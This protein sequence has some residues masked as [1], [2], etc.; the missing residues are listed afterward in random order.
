[1]STPRTVTP[2]TAPQPESRPTTPANPD[3]FLKPDND[4]HIPRDFAT[5]LADYSGIDPANAKAHCLAVRAE[6]WKVH[7]YP[8]I[9]MFL[10][11]DTRQGIMACPGNAF[12]EA[13][14]LLK[15]LE[16]QEPLYLDI[17]CGLGQDLRLLRHAGVPGDR[18]FGTDLLPG[19]IKAGYHLFRDADDDSTGNTIL[20]ASFLVPHDIFTSL[21]GGDNGGDVQ[22][23]AHNPLTPYR[24]RF[25]VVNLGHL[26]HIFSRAEQLEMLT[27]QVIGALL[28]PP[29][30]PQ[31]A[32]GGGALIVGTTV[33]VSSPGG[34]EMPSRHGRGVT[35][36]IHSP[37]SFTALME[38]VGRVT[39]TLW[40]VEARLDNV[41]DDLNTLGQEGLQAFRLAFTCKRRAK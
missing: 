12:E 13:V 4:V 7:R 28:R 25:A 26:L 27:R 30:S 37:E 34:L 41:M 29:V 31:G 23:S 20:S 38:D 2:A 9:G 10:F 14:A 21:D 22:D 19:L 1:M 32:D 18:L 39:G 11:L 35:T 33:G 16:Q 6:A 40:N 3:A 8:C 36:F 17:G 5:F 24:H 15:S